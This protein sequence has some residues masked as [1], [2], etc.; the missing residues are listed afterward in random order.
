[1][2]EHE[3]RELVAQAGRGAE[4]GQGFGRPL[5]PFPQPDRVEVGVADEMHSANR[6]ELPSTYADKTGNGA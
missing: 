2:I 4:R 1:M 6:H 3:F 5:L